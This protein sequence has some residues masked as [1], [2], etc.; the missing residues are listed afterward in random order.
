MLESKLARKMRFHCGI[1]TSL[2]VVIIFHL[3]GPT[4]AS[5]TTLTE[6]ANTCL[7]PCV[8][9]WKGGKESVSC[10]QAGWTEIPS[11]GLESTIQVIFLIRI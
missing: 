9:K 1:I 11:S 2:V 3:A 10:H 7:K 6:P 5:A 4:T 8:C